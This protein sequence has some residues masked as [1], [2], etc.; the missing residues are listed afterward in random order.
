MKSAEHKTIEQ[1]ASEFVNA[2][3][4]RDHSFSPEDCRRLHDGFT[5]A[6]QQIRNDARRAGML[7]GAKKCGWVYDEAHD[8]WDTECGNGF[9]LMNGTP[10]ENEMVF[11]CY[12]GNAI[13]SAANEVEP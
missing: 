7:E 8:K 1:Y 10:K 12:C 2:W 11:C 9:Q 4:V 5:A 3:L 13:E 6:F